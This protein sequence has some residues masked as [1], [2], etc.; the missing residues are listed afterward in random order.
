MSVKAVHTIER[1][2][3]QKYTSGQHSPRPRMCMREDKNC[4]ASG[5]TRT[6]SS[7]SS[8]VNSGPDTHSHKEQ[9]IIDHAGAV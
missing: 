7:I 4:D 1:R 2:S 5:D 6:I 9:I 8:C 3:G